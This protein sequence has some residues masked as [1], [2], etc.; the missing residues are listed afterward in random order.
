MKTIVIV[1]DD[2]D[3]QDLI[4]AIFSMDSRFCV[5]RMVESAEEAIDVVRASGAEIIVLDHGLRGVLSGL[6][7]AQQL[8]DLAP[9]AKII[10]FTAHA[11]IEAQTRR[12]PAIDGFL[13]KDEATRLLPLAQQ[14]TK[15]LGFA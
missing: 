4:E 6:A 11:E 8:K 10:M 5:A 9:Q 7:A 14:M 13:L 3:I 2:P 1:E 12:D 15:M